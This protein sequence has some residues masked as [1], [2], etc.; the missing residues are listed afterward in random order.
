MSA[1]TIDRG[2]RRKRGNVG[3]KRGGKKIGK[4][5]YNWEGKKVDEMGIP[6]DAGWF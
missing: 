2:K 6:G 5:I 1:S 3:K 4:R